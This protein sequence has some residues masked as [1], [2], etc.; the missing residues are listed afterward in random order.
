[1]LRKC[2]RITGSISPFLFEFK[3]YYLSFWSIVLFHVCEIDG[4]IVCRG[5]EHIVHNGFYFDIGEIEPLAIDAILGIFFVKRVLHS[6]VIREFP[7]G[8]HFDA[9]WQKDSQLANTNGSARSFSYFV[10]F[11]RR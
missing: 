3:L 5:I 4:N 9:K 8:D 6:M 2:K 1:M 7:D 10:P 11:K